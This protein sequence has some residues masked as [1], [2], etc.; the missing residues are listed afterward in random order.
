MIVAK[1]PLV[2]LS[3]PWEEALVAKPCGTGKT[4]NEPSVVNVELN[5]FCI[6]RELEH[7]SRLHKLL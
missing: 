4:S 5:A 3:V 2:C 1:G 6:L 7:H